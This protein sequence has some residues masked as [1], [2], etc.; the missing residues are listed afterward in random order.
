MQIS[1]SS[2]IVSRR[3]IDSFNSMFRGRR[4]KASSKDYWSGITGKESVSNSFYCTSFSATDRGKIL[5]S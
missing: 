3:L 1:E 2:S 4:S 5:I